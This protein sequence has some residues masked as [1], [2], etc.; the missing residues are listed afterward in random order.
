MNKKILVF[1]AICFGI[2]YLSAGLFHFL[3]GD[4]ASF[5]GTLF[6]SC[7]MLVPA[8]SVAI[9]QIIFKEKVFRGVGLKFRI[10]IWWLVALVGLPLMCIL[11]TLASGLFPGIRLSLNTPLMETTLNQMAAAGTPMGAW[12]V[13]AVNLVSGL[14][15]GCTINAL[16]ALGEEIAWRGFLPANMEG[17]GFW[18]KCL[19]IGLVWG[20]WHAPIIL[21]G[22]NYPEHPVFGVFMMT[23]LCMLLTPVILHLREKGGSVV[24][25]AI[26]H[27]SMN[28]IAGIA[29]LLLAGY[30]ELLCGMTGLAGFVVMAATD[31]LIYFNRKRG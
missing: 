7:Y 8:L 12:S 30:N 17:W 5:S 20:L 24:T 22:H 9:T 3:G 15:A 6:A 25:A 18:K 1:L 27:G 26:A 2:S 11:A 14:A 16:F 19:V 23:V 10:N 21:M 29:M 31:L 28:A 13:L 4:Y